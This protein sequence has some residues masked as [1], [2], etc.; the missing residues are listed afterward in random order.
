MND[1]CVSSI[2]D[3]GILF[4]NDTYVSLMNMDTYENE[5]IK[6]QIDK[7]KY[8]INKINY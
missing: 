7:I 1:I 4:I 8:Q 6:Y 2:N 5:K 3:K